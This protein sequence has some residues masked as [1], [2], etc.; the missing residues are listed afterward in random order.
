MPYISSRSFV[1]PTTFYFL[2]PFLLRLFILFH[3]L[4]VAT[5]ANAV[6]GVWAKYRMQITGL[7]DKN[8]VLFG[9]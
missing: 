6:Y 3:I 4:Q 9:S 1:F 8:L 2:V 7:T 5:I